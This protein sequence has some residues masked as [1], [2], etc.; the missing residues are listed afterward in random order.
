M[1]IFMDLLFFDLQSVLRVMEEG[2]GTNKNKYSLNGQSELCWER[3]VVYNIPY[4]NMKALKQNL[5][6]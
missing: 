5:K 2:S 4:K 6:Y 3:A 1:A